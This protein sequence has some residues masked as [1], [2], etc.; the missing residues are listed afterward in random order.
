MGGAIVGAFAGLFGGLAVLVLGLLMPA[1]KCP[2]C[3]FV[4]PK[5]GR[6][7]ARPGFSGG[8]ICPKC[9]CEVDRR[10]NKVR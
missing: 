3:G 7:Y 2:E 8:W 9:E 1:R 10:G 5:F 4:F 6:K